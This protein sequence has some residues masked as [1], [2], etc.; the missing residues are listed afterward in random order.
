MDA[1]RAQ[2][3]QLRKEQ[4]IATRTLSKDAGKTACFV[5]QVECQQ[6]FPRL[7]T[8]WDWAQTV[9][10]RPWIELGLLTEEVAAVPEVLVLD[11]MR[12]AAPADRVVQRRWLRTTVAAAREQRGWSPREFSLMLGL[13]PDT[14]ATWEKSQRDLRLGPLF[15]AVRT[16][17]GRVEL[18][19]EKL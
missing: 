19:L 18:T 6:G 8:M 14:W 12:E 9:Q 1:V 17:G 5:S 3:K 16:L 10:R 15:V 4:K 11:V 7:G 2:L 13:D